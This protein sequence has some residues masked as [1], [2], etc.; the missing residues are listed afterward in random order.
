MT[1]VL[2]WN[3]CLLPWGGYILLAHQQH[4]RIV[5]KTLSAVSRTKAGL[6]SNFLIF[7][8]ESLPLAPDGEQLGDEAMFV[9]GMSR[10]DLPEIVNECGSA[11]RPHRKPDFSLRR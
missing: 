6:R 9:L 8:A 1:P 7:S 3:K 2:T 10:S 4:A 11:S 5:D